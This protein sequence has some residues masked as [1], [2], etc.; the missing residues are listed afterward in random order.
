MY[1]DVQPSSKQATAATM[2]DGQNYF[3]VNSN[4]TNT[5]ESP[6]PVRLL[7][8]RDIYYLKNDYYINISK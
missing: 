1:N 4:A 7:I 3:N 6:H 8:V 5:C 2:G